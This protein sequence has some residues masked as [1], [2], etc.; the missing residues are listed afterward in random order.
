MPNIKSA[1][2]QARQNEVR[3][4]RNQSRKSEIKT[5]MKKFELAVQAKDFN[6]AVVFARE[7]ESKL[8]KAK[9]K[10]IFNWRTTARKTSRIAQRLKTAQLAQQQAK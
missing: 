5:I 7:V 10:G 8:A 2:K 9:G 1:K 4:V 6:Q 3:R